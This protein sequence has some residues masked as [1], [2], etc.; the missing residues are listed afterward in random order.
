MGEVKVCRDCLAEK[1][2]SEFY[3]IK[4]GLDP[5]CKPCRRLAVKAYRLSKL[6]AIRAKDRARK[7]ERAVLRQ[8]S[9]S[10]RERHPGKTTEYTQR[11][12][13]KYPEK[14]AA[15]NAVYAAITAGTLKR[16]STCEGCG[17]AVGIL[18]RPLQAHHDD[19]AK[20]LEVRWLCS[21]CHADADMAR[22]RKAS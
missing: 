9:R 15:Q 14:R 6:D 21:G 7:P 8:R 5:V 18:E 10:F 11:F 2:A 13:Q 16:P 17:G 20:P 4:S 22:R 19:Y 12:K 3:A 1:P